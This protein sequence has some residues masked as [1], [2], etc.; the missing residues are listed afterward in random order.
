MESM[1]KSR[2][3]APRKMGASPPVQPQAHL[4]HVQQRQED[5]PAR[6]LRPSM[7]AL[8]E[9]DRHLDERAAALEDAVLELDQEGVAVGTDVLHADPLE[10]RAPDHLE[11]ARAVAQRETRDGA[12]VEVATLAEDEAGE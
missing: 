5:L 8:R 7:A 4:P 6:Q 2:E 1:P 9:H 10:R 11:A 12:H 3:V